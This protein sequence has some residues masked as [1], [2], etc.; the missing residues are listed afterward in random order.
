[1][2]KP[3]EFLGRE[4]RFML[5]TFARLIERRRRFDLGHQVTEIERVLHGKRAELRDKRIRGLAEVLSRK[6]G[7][8]VVRAGHW[9][10]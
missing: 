7:I 1:M 4:R 6:F 5:R 9:I 3:R 8:V 2:P 10:S